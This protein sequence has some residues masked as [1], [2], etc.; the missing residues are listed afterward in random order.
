MCLKRFFLC[1]LLCLL[2]CVSSAHAQANLQESLTQTSS[3]LTEMLS[4]LKVQSND[5][6][7]QLIQLS[8]NLKISEQERNQWMQRS[9]ELSSSLDSINDSLNSSYITIINYENKLKT[10]HKVLTILLILI[11]ARIVTAIIGVVLMLKGVSVPRWLDII[12]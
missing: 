7:Q 6:K 8:E 2:V 5:M 9:T 12:L 1:L 10:Q 3:A 4:T 11:I